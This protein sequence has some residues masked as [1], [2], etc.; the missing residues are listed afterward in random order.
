MLS[1]KCNDEFPRLQLMSNGLLQVLEHVAPFKCTKV[2]WRQCCDASLKTKLSLELIIEEFDIMG[3]INDRFWS[4][5]CS[6]SITNRLLVWSRN[7]DHPT[8]L[9]IARFRLKSE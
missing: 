6:S 5:G 3:G 1:S 4:F 8:L 2:Y 7:N 9:V